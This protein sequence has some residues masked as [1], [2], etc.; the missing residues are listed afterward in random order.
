MSVSQLFPIDPIQQ[1]VGLI[2]AK[3]GYELVASEL[4]L[5][6]PYKSVP[7][8]PARNTDPATSHAAAKTE[9]EVGRFSKKSRQAKLLTLFGALDMTDQGATIALVGLNASPSAFDGCRRRCSD[10]RAAGYL[11]DSGQRRKNKGSDDE[12]IVWRITYEGKSALDNLT[13]T[14]WSR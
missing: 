12:S 6:K 4:E 2:V 8:A 9:A 3:Y 5:H 14:G 7:S 10:L 1:E 13:R 11:A